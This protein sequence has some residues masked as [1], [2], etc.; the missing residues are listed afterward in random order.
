MIP[1]PLQMHSQWPVGRC[2]GGYYQGYI[3]GYSGEYYRRALVYS[4]WVSC[5]LWVLVT[6][7]NL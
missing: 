2:Y 4:E 6:S 5:S 7:E 1:E 3:K